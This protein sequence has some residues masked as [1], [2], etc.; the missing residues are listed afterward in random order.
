VERVIEKMRSNRLA[1]YGHV[2]RR[3]ESHNTNRVM[4]MNVDGHCVK[5][6]TKIKG[7]GEVIE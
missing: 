4:S 7:H 6:E 2:M 1:L 3:D 5:D